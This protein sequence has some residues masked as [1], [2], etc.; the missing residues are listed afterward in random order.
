MGAVKSALLTL[1]GLAFVAMGI[2]LLVRGDP[3][4]VTL[5]WGIIA[6]FGACA[7][8]GLVQLLPKQRAQLYREGA[9]VLRPLREVGTLLA[10]LAMGLGCL[11]LAPYATAQ[12]DT[13]MSYVAYFG[14][15][16][17]GGGST[18]ALWRV[19]NGPPL[20]RID[21]HG[22]ETFGAAARKL[23][24]SEVL[25]IDFGQLGREEGFISFLTA[26]QPLLATDDDD[27]DLDED[28]Y[29]GGDARLPLTISLAQT[30]LSPAEVHAIAERLWRAALNP[31]ALQH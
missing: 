14:A 1:I 9:L 19:F 31:A 25:A 2:F 28:E 8:V 22:V 20:A 17:F 5:A 23:A 4:D 11:S 7:A 12:G 10:G 24:W 21:A 29:A 18:F 30:R 15:I 26:E 27:D 16:F 3:Q 13:F 6:F